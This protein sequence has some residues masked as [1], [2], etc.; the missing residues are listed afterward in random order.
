MM[1]D[2]EISASGREPVQSEKIHLQQLKQAD[3]DS[4]TTLEN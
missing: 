4:Y 3:E 1:Q 2:G